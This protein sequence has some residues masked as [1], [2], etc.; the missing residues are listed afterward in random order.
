MTLQISTALLKSLSIDQNSI[1]MAL[2]S[3]PQGLKSRTLARLTGVSNNSLSINSELIKKLKTEGMEV[4]TE[5]M[6]ATWLW[7]LRNIGGTL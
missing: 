1:L 7:T 2:Q 3:N 5:R 4:H 6:D